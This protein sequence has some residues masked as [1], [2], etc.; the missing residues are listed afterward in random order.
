MFSFFLC[1]QD[2]LRFLQTVG[3]SIVNKKMRDVCAESEC[4]QQLL[5]LLQTLSL[6]VDEIK[7]VDQA[8]RFGNSAYRD[9]HLKMSNVRA[10][11]IP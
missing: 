4:V 8:Q 2:Y 6:W 1:K 5:S 10:V 9:W 3:D 11:A 7:P